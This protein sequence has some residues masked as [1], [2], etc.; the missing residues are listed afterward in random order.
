MQ[1]WG[2]YFQHFI[3]I[4]IIPLFFLIIVSKKFNYNTSIIIGRILHSLLASRSTDID[5]V[6][7]L[8]I[9][10]SSS[11]SQKTSASSLKNRFDHHLAAFALLSLAVLLFLPLPP[12]IQKYEISRCNYKSLQFQDA[13]TSFPTTSPTPC[14]SPD[15]LLDPLA[16]RL[17]LHSP[18]LRLCRASPCPP[19]YST[20]AATSKECQF[21]PRC[22]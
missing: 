18:H 15:L 14:A 12:G 2:Q 20:G 7:V 1:K 11:S 6:I 21:F 17:L 16:C 22:P 13:I 8:K 10:S 19:C 5:T 3:F 9:W 4:I